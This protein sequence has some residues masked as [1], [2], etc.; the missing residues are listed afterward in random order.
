LYRLS[1]LVQLV[2][3]DPV[4]RADF[5]YTDQASL[6]QLL[7]QGRPPQSMP[8][9]DGNLAQSP[10][11]ARTARLLDLLAQ[12]HAAP[13]LPIPCLWLAAER[14]PSHWRA[15]EQEW[16]AWVASSQRRSVD[17]DHWELVMDDAV[18]QQTA[19]VIR[20]WHQQYCQPQER[21]I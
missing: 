21:S 5:C 2:L 11:L 15:A 19:G 17:A 10:W 13:L 7:E 16:Q 18:A 20:Q 6:H 4:C 9:Q 8:L 3:L 1:E 12:H 14:R